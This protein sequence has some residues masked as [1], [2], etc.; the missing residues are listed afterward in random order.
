MPWIPCSDFATPDWLVDIGVADSVE[1][2]VI[3]IVLLLIVPALAR[4]GFV[5]DG[6]APQPLRHRPRRPC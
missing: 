4:Q 1:G 5:R 3:Q 6:R 2:I